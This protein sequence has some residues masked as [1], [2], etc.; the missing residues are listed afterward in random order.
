MWKSSGLAIATSITSSMRSRSAPSSPR[1][2]AASQL[3]DP[4][5]DALGIC[6][7]R[8]RQRLDLLGC[9]LAHRRHRRRQQRRVGLRVRSVQTRTSVCP[10]TWWRAKP[11]RSTAEPREEGAEGELG[12]VAIGAIGV[13][14]AGDQLRA[15]AGQPRGTPRR[16]AACRATRRRAQARSSRWPAAGARA[17]WSSR[18]GRPAP[19]MGR[20]LAE[21]LAARPAAGGSPSS[22]RPR[23]WSGSPPPPP[24]EPRRSPWPSRSPGRRRERRAGPSRRRRGPR[25]R[26]PAPARPGEVGRR[27]A[28]LIELRAPPRAP[29]A[30]SSRSNSSQPCLGEQLRRVGEQPL[31]ED[32]GALPS[33]VAPAELLA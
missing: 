27:A 13:E 25:R 17:R 2:A 1:R 23:G 12:A 10:S 8:L 22:A 26:P 21:A 3:P 19:A 18:S 28:A 11:A 15:P 16:R 20:T 6:S 4:V 7:E 32:H 24:C 31:A 5:A 30:W 29:A 33:G 14:S 9:A